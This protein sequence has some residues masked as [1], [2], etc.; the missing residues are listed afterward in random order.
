MKYIDANS[1]AKSTTAALSMPR[2]EQENKIK[3]M[4]KL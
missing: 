3:R 1:P 2:T 4:T